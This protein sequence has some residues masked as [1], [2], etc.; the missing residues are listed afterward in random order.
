MPLADA[1]FAF[2]NLLVGSGPAATACVTFRYPDGSK[3]YA[4]TD[5]LPLGG[6]SIT[7]HGMRYV[8]VETGADGAGSTIVELERVAAP[9]P[10]LGV[11]DALI[12]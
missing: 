12:G 9:A 8:V 11:D 7:R 2:Q 10:E 4:Y 5:R 3:E 1:G 6:E